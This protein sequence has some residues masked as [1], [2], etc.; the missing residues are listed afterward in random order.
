VIGV[1]SIL[2]S[3]GQILA[4]IASLAYFVFA[5]AVLIPSLAVVFRRLHDLDK[6]AWWILIGI[7]PLIGSLL[8]LYWFCQPGTSGSNQYGPDPKHGHDVDVFS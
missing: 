6:S 4:G 8:L 5:L 2:G 3:V 1:A 7:I